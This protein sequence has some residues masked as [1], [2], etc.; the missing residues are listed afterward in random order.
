M[1]QYYKH[2]NHQYSILKFK[3]I[4]KILTD[5]L[6]K[7]RSIESLNKLLYNFDQKNMTPGKLINFNYISIN[8]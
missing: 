2:K 6:K 1:N 7:K 8:Y 4:F 5:Y 3:N